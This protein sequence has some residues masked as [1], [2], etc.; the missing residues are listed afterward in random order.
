[1]PIDNEEPTQCECGSCSWTTEDEDNLIWVDDRLLCEDCRAYCNN[2][3]EY[4]WNDN[5]HY[6]EGVGDYCESCWENDTIY[7]ERCNSSYPD[8]ES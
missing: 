1:M 6:V 5:T 4:T 7:C 8:S 3:E 2:C